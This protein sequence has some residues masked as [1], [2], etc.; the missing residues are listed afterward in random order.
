MSGIGCGKESNIV[1]HRDFTPV[2]AGRDCVK[3]QK[4]L[5]SQSLGFDSNWA[6]PKYTT[7]A[8]LLMTTWS[9]LRTSGLFL[10]WLRIVQEETYPGFNRGL[11]DVS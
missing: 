10:V 2:F 9:A 11:D 8:L 3:Q 4:I 1:Q 6:F 5:E 7:E